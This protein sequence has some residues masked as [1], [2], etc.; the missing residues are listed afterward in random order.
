MIFRQSDS[1]GKL[2]TEIPTE[3]GAIV[4][5]YNLTGV[6]HGSFHNPCISKTDNSEPRESIEIRAVVY[7]DD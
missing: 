5:I 4:L 2:G 6:P 7:F 1:E 3:I